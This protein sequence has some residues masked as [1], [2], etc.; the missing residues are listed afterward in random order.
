MHASALIAFL[1]LTPSLPDLIS[2]IDGLSVA[3]IH[4]NFAEAH[5]GHAHEA[6][7]IM[8]PKG[9]PVRAVVSGVVRKLF[10]SVAGGNTIYQFDAAGTYC[11]YYA[12]LD[13]YADGLKEGMQVKAGD[14]IAYVGF[15]G[16]ASPLA[17]HLHFAVTELGPEKQW[18][19]GKVVNPFPALLEAVK[20]AKAPTP[21][22][23]ASKAHGNAL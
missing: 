13:H 21:K 19:K 11:Y 18:W 4:D 8:S 15:T 10:V 3:S 23:P 6:I 1:L 5:F 12:H 17:P 20:R 16:N 22:P 7:D 9:T 14:V 2:P